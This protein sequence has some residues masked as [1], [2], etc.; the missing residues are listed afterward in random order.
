MIEAVNVRQDLGGGEVPLL[1][2]QAVRDHGQ[3]GHLVVSHGGRD[4]GLHGHHAVDREGLSDGIVECCEGETQLRRTR[5]DW[6]YNARIVQIQVDH[7]NV[8]IFKKSEGANSNIA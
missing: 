2:L 8:Q 5:S 6:S 3:H 7:R 4:S 1:R